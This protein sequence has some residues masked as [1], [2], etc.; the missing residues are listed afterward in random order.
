MLLLQLS[1]IE[2][3]WFIISSVKE[4][5]YE[6]FYCLGKDPDENNYVLMASV[7]LSSAFDVVNIKLL[8]KRLKIMGLP[9]E[10]IKLIKEWLK[11]I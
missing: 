2:I 1:V 4:Y 11:D 10:L 6:R 7:D 3:V 8:L 5:D 9:N